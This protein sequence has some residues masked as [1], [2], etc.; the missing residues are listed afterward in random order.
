MNKLFEQWYRLHDRPVNGCRYES[1]YKRVLR[2]AF[3]AGR[4]AE[5]AKT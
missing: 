2:D 4:R 5:G 3:N 1:T